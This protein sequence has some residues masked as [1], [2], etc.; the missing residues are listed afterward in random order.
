MNLLLTL[1]ERILSSALGF[2]LD[3]VVD[4]VPLSFQEQGEVELA[5]AS[6]GAYLY[7]PIFVDKQLDILR[8]SYEMS[9]YY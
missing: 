9:D 6:Y 5:E 8:D 4:E 1:A 2:G 7:A 3:D